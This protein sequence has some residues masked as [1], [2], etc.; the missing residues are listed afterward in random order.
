[1][2]THLE[3]PHPR[4]AIKRYGVMLFAVLAAL[5]MNLLVPQLR[6]R[7]SFVPF[8]G[9]VTL[10]AW[11]GGR[12]PGLVSCLLA[13]L[14]TNYF[15]FE[16]AFTFTLSIEAIVPLIVFVCTALAISSLT[17]ELARA[18][19]RTRE[20]WKRFEQ[21]FKS[22]GD[23]V[24]VFTTTGNVDYVNRAAE[25]LLDYSAREITG[26]SAGKLLTLQYKN[27]VILTEDPIQRVMAS[28]QALRLGPGL[29]ISNRLGK[30]I[31]VEADG[32]P[33][34]GADGKIQ[35]VVLVLRDISEREK[36]ESQIQDY[37]V[38]LRTLASE[39][40]LA[41]ERER[42]RIAIGLH[43]RV[44]QTLAACNIH[45]RALLDET[46]IEVMKTG[47]AEINKTLKEIISETRSLTFQLSPPIL[48]EFGLEPALKWLTQ[49]MA[50]DHNL[51]CVFIESG[52]RV[53]LP[54][55]F[56][57]I[58]FQ[59][60]R[61]LLINVIKH[62][63]ATKATL[64]I[65]TTGEEIG[66]WVEDDGVGFN[67]EMISAHEDGFGLFSIRERMRHLGGRLEVQSVE[68]KGTKVKLSIPIQSLASAEA[69]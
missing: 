44:G 36:S 1:M 17:S 45:A 21:T 6:Q 20:Q 9:A 60:A 4:S 32:S 29:R 11:Y 39:V 65:E 28:R 34:I 67:T 25:D 50:K 5:G 3:S 24:I 33:I 69:V 26:R 52:M 18:E 31:P 13:G 30:V 37:Q 64:T 48:Y 53:P 68:E 7:E 66:L 42:H 46:S 54:V 38:S 27:N 2:N 47:F 16:P 51:P 56:R 35:G 23:A 43:D 8:F 61:E 55:E 40:L 15:L 58:F 14:I 10:S 49:Q 41:E 63:N 57:V 19:Q 22:I 62:A 12:G 59:S